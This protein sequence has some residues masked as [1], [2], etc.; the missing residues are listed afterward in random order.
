MRIAG[1]LATDV[2]GLPEMPENL[3]PPARAS[4]F[5][6]QEQQEP[7]LSRGQVSRAAVDLDLELLE[8]EPHP[9]GPELGAGDAQRELPATKDRADVGPV[10]GQPEALDGQAA[11]PGEDVEE[12]DV[13]LGEPLVSRAPE[14]DDSERCVGRR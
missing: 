1:T 3:V 5:L 4:R 8:V 7:H 13:A 6:C 10:G 14:D 12:R 9:P 11:Q 2:V